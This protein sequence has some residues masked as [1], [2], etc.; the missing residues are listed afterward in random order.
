MKA[1]EKCS[2]A[3]DRSPESYA[4]SVEPR[5]LRV[6]TDNGDLSPTAKHVS[7]VESFNECNDETI[8]DVRE[9]KIRISNST[10]TDTNTKD[11]FI[12]RDKE[13]DKDEMS[14][15]STE[16]LLESSI[17]E[18]ATPPVTLNVADVNSSV[19]KGKS[20]K[21]EKLKGFLSPLNVDSDVDTDED[22]LTASD[23][24]HQAALSAAIEEEAD[25]SKQYETERDE[26]LASAK[27]HEEKLAI[28]LADQEA[29]VN[30]MNNVA[31]GDDEAGEVQDDNKEEKSENDKV[32]L[33]LY[34]VYGV[35]FMNAEVYVSFSQI[36]FF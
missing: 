31:D 24:E 21:N 34:V 28:E 25:L 36:S 6:V 30:A 35:V 15:V 22:G 18:Q 23:V 29:Y 2:G 10:C 11:S 27:E 16:I 19:E 32:I 17:K 1:T 8:A 7:E 5:V 33:L 12:C 14:V 9:A 4:H 3:R 13:F 26:F 20:D